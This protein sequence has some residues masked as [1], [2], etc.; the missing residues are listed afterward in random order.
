MKRIEKTSIWENTLATRKDGFEKER[1]RLRT[2]FLGLR[3][4]TRHLVSQIAKVLPDL[5]QHE[6]SHL[7]ALWE[8]AS[9]IIGDD[10]QLTPL[11]G[12]VLGC[13]FLLHDSALCYEAYENGK[14]G[15]RETVQWKDAYED[16]KESNKTINNEDAEHHADFMTLRSLHAYQA[17]KLLEISWKNP[18]T[19]KDTFLLDDQKLR[20]HLGKLIGQIASSHH[21]DIERVISEFSNQINVPSD[22]PREWRVDP[23]KLACILRCADAA[24]IDNERAPDF[25]YALLKRGGVSYNHWK[26]QNRLA[27]VDID[28]QDPKNETLLFTST[29][30]FKETDSN[31]W[32]VAY[33]AICL[34]N[35]ELQSCNAVLLKNNKKP[36]K[37]K[38]IK[39]IESPESMATYIKADG[40]EPR[41]AKVHVGS[42]ERIVHNLGGEML[43][44]THSDNLQIVLRE[45]IQ[46]S[47][48]SIKARKIYDTV[49]EGKIIININKNPNGIYIE[50]KDNGIGM[51]ERVLTGPLLDFGTSF[52]TSSLVQDE[53]PGLRSS[54]FKSIG[55]FGIGFYSIFMIADQ[56]VVSSR[57]Y[58]SGLDD[59]RQLKFT[60]GFTL[61]PIIS[62]G[63]VQDVNYVTS[64]QIKLKPEI[65]SDNLKIK[66]LTNRSN[67][68]G[69]DTP[70]KDYLSVICTGLDVNVFYND[71]LNIGEKKIHED[72]YSPNFN[73]YEWLM[74]I[75]FAN[76]QPYPSKIKEYVLKNFLRLKPIIENDVIK[77]IAAIN[78]YDSRV[79]NFLNVDTVGGLS[80]RV[81][82]RHADKFIG[83]MDY[84]PRSAKRDIEDPD[85]SIESLQIWAEDQLDE[86]MKSDLTD[87]EKYV[88]SAS[89]CQ[90]KVD[91]I[92]FAMILVCFNGAYCYASFAELAEA[93]LN[94][95]IAFLVSGFEKKDYIETYHHIKELPNSILI[96]SIEPSSFLYLKVKEGIPEKNFSILDCLYRMC[97]KKGFNPILTEE[98]LVGKNIHGEYID[99][100]MLTSRTN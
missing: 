8:T 45:L 67:S 84:K 22:F 68:I 93:S 79:Q 15:I 3:D 50:V 90:F 99:A 32:F 86:L 69:F 54:K 63:G 25:L 23:V 47:R 16:I 5:T 65:I 62:K 43:Y 44:G 26:A 39:G 91:P 53:F 82:S 77:G 17:E 30:A 89:L 81:H 46:N 57:N 42:I 80:S 20:N 14:D 73:A 48:D 83:Y 40:W 78:T 75:S 37:I 38:K 21:W 97:I 95:K 1:E 9:L 70:L 35:K 56:V 88:A 24:H 12:F 6:I 19:G 11:E 55:K 64:V 59:V 72:I 74:K 87:S 29:I 49:F 60:N 34:L 85:A 58:K 10:Y 33:D 31:A 51:S 96:V 52:W 66:I 76:Y 4:N 36:F 100:L 71:Y 98:K 7:D 2:S 28:Q 18:D 27:K 61:R 41:S 94:K 92:D 13:S